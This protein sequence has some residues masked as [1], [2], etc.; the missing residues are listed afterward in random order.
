MLDMPATPEMTATPERLSALVIQLQGER[1]KALAEL[2]VCRAERDQMRAMLAQVESNAADTLGST[3]LAAKTRDEEKNQELEE[4]REALRQTKAELD[5]T[6]EELAR[7]EFRL[8]GQTAKMRRQAAPTAGR[9][10]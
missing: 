3:E 9:D 1:D 2:T 5:Q 6:K 10:W 7:A 4:C 8:R